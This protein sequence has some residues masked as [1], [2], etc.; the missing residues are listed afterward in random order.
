MPRRAAP[1]EKLK[2]KTLLAAAE[3]F[4]EKGYAQATTRGIAQ[5]AGVEVSSMNR[6]FCSKENILCELVVYVLEEQFQ[7][8]AQMLRGVTADPLLF[9]AMETTMQLHMAESSPA[10]HDLYMTA[11][12]LPNSL[13]IIQQMI[14]GKLEQIFR[15]Q[16][17][18]LTTKDF[19]E[20]E[21]AS[22]GVMRN[23][24]ARTCDMY[25]TLERKTICFLEATFRIF[26][27]PEEKIREAIS[28]VQR[29]DFP[30]IAGNV[31]E[32]MLQCLKDR[33]A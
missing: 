26:R 3:L 18:G 9:Y 10:V 5:K 15:A 22:S 32:N 16:L 7:S 11:Y 12:S 24:M 20:L 29:F 6:A 23:F 1:V 33:I 2:E 28:F 4:L 27:T 21:I 14:T 8:A 31:I 13:H 19:Y 30:D 17:P 25:F